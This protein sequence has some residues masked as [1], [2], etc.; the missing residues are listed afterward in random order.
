MAIKSSNLFHNNCNIISIISPGSHSE[1][2]VIYLKF[3]H[4]HCDLVSVLWQLQVSN[5]YA[6]FI[7]FV[8]LQLLL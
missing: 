3:R 4:C 7:D 6:P 2:K 8:L 5:K 1:F